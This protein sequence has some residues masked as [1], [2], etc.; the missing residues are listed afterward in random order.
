M[1]KK[2]LKIIF[3]IVESNGLYLQGARPSRGRRNNSAN[4][5]RYCKHHWKL[6]CLSYHSKE[7]RHEVSVGIPV[8]SATFARFLMRKI[9]CKLLT[10]E[11]YKSNESK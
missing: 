5:T 3:F 2:C 10:P 4:V 9:A 6:F 1:G 11:H 8:M 7:Q